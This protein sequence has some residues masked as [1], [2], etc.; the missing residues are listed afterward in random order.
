MKC[1]FV[2]PTMLSTI[3]TLAGFTVIR[4]NAQ[5]VPRVPGATN[6]TEE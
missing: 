1:S 2:H 4:A 3:A 5:A 6:S